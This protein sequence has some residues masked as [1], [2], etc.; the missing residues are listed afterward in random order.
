MPPPPGFS[1]CR[2]GEILSIFL[3]RINGTAP[4]PS[5]GN[6]RRRRKPG[7]GVE[8]DLVLSVR[9]GRFGGFTFHCHTVK[10]KPM[11]RLTPPRHLATKR[12]RRSVSFRA[13][14]FSGFHE[15]QSSPSLAVAL[16]RA[17]VSQSSKI[18]ASARTALVVESSPGGRREGCGSPK[19]LRSRPGS[20]ESIRAR[21][22]GI[23]P[24][25]RKGGSCGW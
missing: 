12:Q 20:P 17:R 5:R 16:I 22:G 23:L 7:L 19:S 9:S 3:L 10:M 15:P 1:A 14:S 6:A 13:P 24:G 25:W 21:V 2:I 11:C 8:G 18:P 4:P